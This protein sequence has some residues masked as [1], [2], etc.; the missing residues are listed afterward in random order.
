MKT[1]LLMALTFLLSLT[2]SSCKE[3]ESIMQPSTL[4]SENVKNMVPVYPP[5]T[6]P[7]PPADLRYRPETE[8]RQ[9]LQPMINA[10]SYK[11]QQYGLEPS[12]WFS[13]PNDPR[14]AEVAMA[15][16]RLEQI[17][18]EGNEVRYDALNPPTRDLQAYNTYDCAM[19]AVGVEAAI[20]VFQNG[21]NNVPPMVV[22]R[23][24]MKIASRTIGYVGAAWAVY[25]FG[26]CMGWY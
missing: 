22:R 20:L 4:S 26:G 15:I 5:G 11:M 25:E 2:F 16:D 13:D 23:A 10:G 18:R 6:Y 17:Y 9:H 1:K 21:I 24:V 7:I 3:D 19:R 8:I 12:A 14:L